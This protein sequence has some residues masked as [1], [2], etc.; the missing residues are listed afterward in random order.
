[1]SVQ[2]TLEQPG[3]SLPYR[4]LCGKTTGRHLCPGEASPAV[5]SGGPADNQ[6]DAL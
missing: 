6:A 4:I 5:S 1:M 2:S 3:P